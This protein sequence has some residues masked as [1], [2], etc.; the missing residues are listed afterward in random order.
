M[1]CRPDPAD[2]WTWSDWSKARPFACR[3]CKRIP[4]MTDAPR[5]K[6]EKAVIRQNATPE[7]VEALAARIEAL[8]DGTPLYFLDLGPASVGAITGLLD[9]AGPDYVCWP[10]GA[11]LGVLIALPPDPEPFTGALAAKAPRGRMVSAGEAA[12]ILRGAV[13]L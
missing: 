4:L 1:N 13:L 6:K 5:T 11:T 9:G 12:R 3:P 2:R 7:Q 8:S 10:Q